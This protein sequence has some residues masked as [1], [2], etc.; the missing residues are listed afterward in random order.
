MAAD[1]FV[2]VLKGL[3]SLTSLLSIADQSLGIDLI[4]VS[5]HPD[6]DIYT[7]PTHY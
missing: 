6:N 5:L 2:W 7:L 3:L 4:H 1:Y